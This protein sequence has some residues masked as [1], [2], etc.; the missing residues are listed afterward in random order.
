MAAGPPVDW[1]DRFETRVRPVLAKNCYA[2]YTATKLGGLQLDTREAALRGGKSGPAIVPGDPENSLLIQV[3][4]QTHAALKM[5]PSGRLAQS[6]LDD[7][8][9]WVRDGAVWPENQAALRIA[10]GQRNFW[11]FQPATSA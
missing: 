2:C 4:R 1:K 8:A 3:I 10:S 11:S 9:P 7:M 5:P 6:E